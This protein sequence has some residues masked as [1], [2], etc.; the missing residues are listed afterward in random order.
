MSLVLEKNDLFLYM[1]LFLLIISEARKKKYG[2]WTGNSGSV[3]ALS[4]T[5][6]L[7]VPLKYV[8]VFEAGNNLRC[9]L[10]ISQHCKACNTHQ[11]AAEDSS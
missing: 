10:D 7:H 11:S 4:A 3:D 8:P 6:Q 5:A 2:P 1:C 9:F